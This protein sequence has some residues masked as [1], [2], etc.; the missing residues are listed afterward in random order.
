MHWISRL[1]VAALVFL[2]VV[3]AAEAARIKPTDVTA[4]SYYDDLN[5]PDDDVLY[6]PRNAAD[7]KVS[8]VWV[9]GEEG[10]GL[11]SWVKLDLGEVRTIHRLRVWNGN[12]YSWDYWQRHNRIREMEIEFSD[13]TVQKVTLQDKKIPE[14]IEFSKPVSTNSVKLKILGIYRGN[15]FNDTVISEIQVLDDAPEAR[16]VPASTADSGH[17]PEDAD[18]SYEVSNVFDGM[19]DTMWCENQRSGDGTGTWLELRY[20]TPVTASKLQLVNGNGYALS[21][22]METNRACQA[23]LSFSDGSSEKVTLRDVMLEQSVPFAKRTASSIRIRFD[24]VKQGTKAK[25]PDYNILC[26]SEAWLA[27]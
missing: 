4:S 16:P 20:A 3:P 1:V 24:T 7:G 25:D 22:W 21:F 11:G 17:P 6:R 18:G 10:S 19:S 26:I 9:E 12:W 5:N 23:T 27:D 14:V 8:S 15:T 13:G 2:L